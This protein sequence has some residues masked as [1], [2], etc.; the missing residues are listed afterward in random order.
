MGLN[1]SGG[2]Q[3]A[4]MSQEA[5]DISKPGMEAAMG[6]FMDAIN[7]GGVQS[8]Q[9]LYSQAAEKS[10][11]ASNQAQIKL[12]EDFDRTGISG[13]PFAERAFRGAEQ[14]GQLNAARIPMEMENTDYWK[15]L[16]TFFPGAQS[17]MNSGISGMGPAEG[18]DANQMMAM[19]QL[20]ASMFD[21]ST[22]AFAGGDN[23]AFSGMES[24][25][26]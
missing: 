24:L 23:S 3:T 19:G 7:S 11:Q 12:G 2:D 26:G 17:G 13:T 18:I 5:F 6:M 16:S 10:L 14:K 15:I 25:F 4:A 9:P 20:M 21:T 22:G 8:R 1:K